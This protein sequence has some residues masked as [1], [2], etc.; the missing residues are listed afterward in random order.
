MLRTYKADLHVHTCLSPCGDLRMSPRTI[1]EKARERNVDILGICDHNSAENV[2]AVQQAA[3]KYK[4]SVLPGLEVT[5]QEEVHILALFNNLSAAWAL[6]EYVYDK[7]PGT[8]DEEAFGLQ[9]VVNSEGE[10][11]Y[12]N[13][14]LLIGASTI[15]IGEMV[16]SIH[17]LDGL[18]IASHVDKPS[19]SLISQLGFIPEDLDLDAL[20]VS[21]PHNAPE[22]TGSVSPPQP[23]AK[24]G[25]DL[26]LTCASDAHFP[27][28]I[29]TACTLFFLEE[30]TL[31][32]IKLAL[33][34]QNNRKILHCDV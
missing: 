20:E 12:F 32:E 27:E 10:V 23:P 4:I 30:G 17:A 16:R 1:V 8:N 15:P 9:V 5:T 3:E 19:F 18:A 33:N 26:P 25:R 6:Q 14:R 21:K 34:K 31:E 2:P 29:G 7:L 24:G 22:G 13:S 28:E 11:L